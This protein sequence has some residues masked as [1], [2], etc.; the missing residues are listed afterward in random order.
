MVE[1]D[2]TLTLI[3]FGYK[4]ILDSK[5]GFDDVEEFTMHA[6]VG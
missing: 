5:K 2:D 1:G 3:K 6:K 4:H